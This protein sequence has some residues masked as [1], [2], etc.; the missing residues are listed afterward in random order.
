MIRTAT[1]CTLFT[2]HAKHGLW[3]SWFCSCVSLGRN[4]SPTKCRVNVYGSTGMIHAGGGVNSLPE[5]W[6]LPALHIHTT[7]R[8]IV[9]KFE[10]GRIGHGP[11]ARLYDVVRCILYVC[12]GVMCCVP[13]CWLCAI[14]LHRYRS[15]TK[16]MVRVGQLGTMVQVRFTKQ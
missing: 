7:N 12:G 9:V 3:C 11:C 6:S 10:F 5:S 14:V 8:T 4:S 1:E 13:C 2:K 16:H 15:M